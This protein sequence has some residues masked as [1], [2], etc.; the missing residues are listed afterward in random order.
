[1]RPAA[2]QRGQRRSPEHCRPQP[3]QAEKGVLEE[4]EGEEKE[5]CEEKEDNE[6]LQE[7]REERVEEGL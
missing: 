7:E 4:E 6:A 2:L 3:S 1:M 5:E